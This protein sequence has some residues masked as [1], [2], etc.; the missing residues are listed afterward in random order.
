MVAPDHACGHTTTRTRHRPPRSAQPKRTSLL[1]SAARSLKVVHIRGAAVGPF[2]N[3]HCP[4]LSLMVSKEFPM[5]VR[6]ARRDRGFTL[7]EL[8]VVIAVIAILIALL[9]PAVQKVR[10]AA[11]RAQCQNN[12]KQMALAMHGYHDAYKHFPPGFD[13]AAPGLNWGW[14]AMVLPFVEQRRCK[15]ISHSMRRSRSRRSRRRRCRSSSARPTAIRGRT[16]RGS[17][18]ATARA[19]IRSASRF[20]MAARRSGCCRSP[21]APATRS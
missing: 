20:P 12:L 7:I 16:T 19:T 3:G 18:R 4:L 1:H 21:T 10:G 2:V 5:R 17:P 8:L 9:V 11:A 15:T 13:N 6:H 14:A